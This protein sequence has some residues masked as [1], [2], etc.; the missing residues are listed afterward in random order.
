MHKFATHRNINKALKQRRLASTY[1][2]MMYCFCN[3]IAYQG[4]WEKLLLV[5]KLCQKRASLKRI[6][7]ELQYC[8][9][10]SLLHNVFERRINQKRTKLKA[11]HSLQHCNRIRLHCWNSSSCSWKLFNFRSESW[12]LTGLKAYTSSTVFVCN[13]Y[14]FCLP[15]M[16]KVAHVNAA[17]SQHSWFE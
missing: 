12:E 9:K 6:V 11:L 5:G 17:K 10:C 16:A 13:M 1:Y 15:Y 2:Y 4:L 14:E 3:Y 8:W 7:P